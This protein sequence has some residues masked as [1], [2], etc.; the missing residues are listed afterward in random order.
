VESPDVARDTS[1]YYAFLMLPPAKRNA[2]VAVWD[3]CRA[4]DDAVDEAAP[5][6]QWPLDAT[7]R[8]TAERKL[9]L[10]RDE[11][12]R[13][14]NQE[15]SR[16]LPQTRQGRALRPLVTD[17][18]LPRPPFEDLIDGVA[19]DLAIDRYETI[20]E[21][22]EYCR[23]VA[24]AVGLVCIEIFGCRDPR[25]RDYAI[26]LGLALQLTNI[27][28]DVGVD[29]ARGRVYLPQQDLRRFNCTEDALTKGVVTEPVRALLAFEIARAREY[30]HRA[31]V[32]LPRADARRL[33]AAEIMGAIYQDILRR[34]ESEGY[35]VFS[36]VIRVP[37]PARFL[38]A[39]T[40]WVRTLAGLRLPVQQGLGI[41]D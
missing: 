5:E 20:D 34:I 31:A 15:D 22:L 29:L 37:R 6:G 2:I 30:F 3:F 14:F 25:A 32:A 41:R 17:F 19:M 36:G 33:V 28:R 8:R 12:A 39:L 7:A 26:N 27:V 38:I 23:R 4:V 10:W 18:N 11:L 9:A 40:T 13:C 1:F 21:L 35:D 16:G 24:S